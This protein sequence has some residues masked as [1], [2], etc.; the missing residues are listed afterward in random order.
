MGTGCLERLWMSHLWKC[1]RSGWM[2]L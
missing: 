1:S 2:G